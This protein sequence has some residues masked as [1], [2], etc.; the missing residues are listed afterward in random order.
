MQN[1]G[2]FVCLFFGAT[3]EDTPHRKERRKTSHKV[4]GKEPKHQS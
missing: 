3:N 4:R 2:D 1:L